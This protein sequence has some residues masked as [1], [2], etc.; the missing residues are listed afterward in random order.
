MS[1]CQCGGGFQWV[2]LQTK[3]KS[4][5]YNFETKKKVPI[6]VRI[7]VGGLATI[8]LKSG[9]FITKNPVHRILGWFPDVKEKDVFGIIVKGE[10]RA[11]YTYTWSFAWTEKE[12]AVLSFSSVGTSVAC[13][14]CCGAWVWV[15]SG[16]L[17]GVVDASSTCTHPTDYVNQVWVPRWR[18]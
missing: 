1:V 6:V 2:V 12:C 14:L 18:K 13:G 3:V 16:R 17:Y 9:T 8:N 7:S 4:G 10:V 5:K 11:P 15:S